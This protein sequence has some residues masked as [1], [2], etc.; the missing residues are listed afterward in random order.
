M[1]KNNFRKEGHSY[2]LND[3]RIP[4]VT[5]IIK[6]LNPDKY[7]YVNK[8]YLKYKSDLGTEI[9]DAI[10]LSDTKDVSFL[11]SDEVMKYVKVYQ[12]F[13]NE[14][15][16]RSY[17]NEIQLYSKKLKYA[18][19]IDKICYIDDKLSVVDFKT[20]VYSKDYN[21]QIAAYTNAAIENGY[22]IEDLYV[23]YI[24]EERYKI[25][26]QKAYHYYLRIF[27]ALL[28][29]YNYKNKEDKYEK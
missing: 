19:T 1:K 17:L 26:K 24:N 22:K 27:K 2:Y 25:Y 14:V 16:Y 8:D 23:I 29:V 13:K 3:V 4:S 12:K 15:N 21:I 20:G 10:N 18:C 6:V 5:E 28:T 7:K 9:H 11:F